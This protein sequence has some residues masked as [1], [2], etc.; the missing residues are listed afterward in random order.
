MP[1]TLLLLT[2][3]LLSLSTTCHSLHLP[4][5]PFQRFLSSAGLATS[6]FFTSH[7]SVQA[8]LT[9][10]PYNPQIQY[11]ILTPPAPGSTMAK[12]GDLVAIR[13]LASYNGQVIDDTFKTADPYYY[14]CGVGTV[15]AGL[16]E[17]VT[18]MHEGE[19]VKLRFGGDLA[20]G[21]KGMKSAPGRA[22]VPPN[23]VVDYEVCTLHCITNIQC[24]RALHYIT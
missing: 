13:F 5:S 10:A 22:R 24:I 21:S 11:E 12:P 20:F 15:V 9:P 1:S 16:D 17:A 2:L 7:S 8:A 6:V 23:A 19:R 4:K 14:R 3:T 18:H